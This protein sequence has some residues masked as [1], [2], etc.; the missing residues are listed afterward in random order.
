MVN[1]IKRKFNKMVDARLVGLQDQLGFLEQQIID[2]DHRIEVLESELGI[3]KG[4]EPTS[5]MC[6]EVLRQKEIVNKLNT[7]VG[8]EKM[9]QGIQDHNRSL[10]DEWFNGKQK[11]QGDTE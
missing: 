4:I 7:I 8:I 11:G 6:L 3:K 10:I 2:K 1:F 5:P 9:K